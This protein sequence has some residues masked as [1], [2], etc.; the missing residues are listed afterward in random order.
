MAVTEGVFAENNMFIYNNIWRL[1]EKTSSDE[2][3]SYNRKL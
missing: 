3:N 2:I 1:R